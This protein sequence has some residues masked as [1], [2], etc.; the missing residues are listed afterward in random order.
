MAVYDANGDG[1]KDVVTNLNVHGSVLPG[2]SSVV[3]QVV[4]SLL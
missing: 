1:L 3:T 2:M 4:T